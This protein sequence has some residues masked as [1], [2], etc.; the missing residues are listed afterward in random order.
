MNFD[1]QTS[2]S[3]KTHGRKGQ[4]DPNGLKIERG[5]LIITKVDSFFLHEDEILAFL[6]L[7]SASHL[8]DSFKHRQ[9]GK[10][11]LPKTLSFY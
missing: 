2:F 6:I 4:K 3:S 11:Y 8:F 1:H 7:R 5:A 10:Q 9:I